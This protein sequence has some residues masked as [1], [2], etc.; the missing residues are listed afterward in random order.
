MGFHSCGSYLLG[1][2]ATCSKRALGG[3]ASLDFLGMLLKQQDQ[4]ESTAVAAGPQ[5]P[6]GLESLHLLPSFNGVVH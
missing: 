4:V 1:T 2:L 5:I 3:S 6:R